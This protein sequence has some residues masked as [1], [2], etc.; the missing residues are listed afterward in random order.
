MC[1]FMTSK[2]ILKTTSPKLTAAEYRK[3]PR[4]YSNMNTDIHACPGTQFWERVPQVF[5]RLQNRMSDAG[6]RGTAVRVL[7]APPAIPSPIKPKTSIHK[8]LCLEPRK[9]RIKKLGMLVYFTW[10]PM[11]CAQ[12][13]HQRS[14]AGSVYV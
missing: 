7:V 10:P 3:K 11:C 12:R 8:L 13:F 14:S 1:F 9:P 2:S 6:A 4:T 5:G